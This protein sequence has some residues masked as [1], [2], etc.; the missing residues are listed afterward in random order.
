[1]WYSFCVGDVLKRR[2]K[3]SKFESPAH[4]AL[5]NLLV[6]S[7]HLRSLVDEACGK[8]GI[9]QA[10]FNVLRI[11]RGAHPGGYPRGEISARMMDRAPDVTRLIDRLQSAGLVERVKTEDDRRL[12]VTRITRGG[13]SLLAKLDAPIRAINRDLARRASG[14]D[15]RELSRICEALYRRDDAE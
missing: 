13:L 5:L 10:Q 4:E 14:K 15:L 12:S 2:I 6:A 9:T 11:L 1:V 3:Q 8:R 7:G